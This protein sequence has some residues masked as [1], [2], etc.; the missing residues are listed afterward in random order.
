MKKK[1][2]LI[3]LA[4]LLVLTLAF[5][6]YAAVYYRAADTALKALES[7]EVLVTE[8]EYGWFFD[9]PSTDRVLVFY[10]GAK[11]EETAYAP[12]LHR[13]AEQGVDVCLV[14]MPFHLAFFRM[15]AADSLM[16]QYDYEKWYI[17]GHSLGGA[18]AADYAASHD[19]DGVILLAAY[20]TRDV[21]EP[22]LILYG[23]ED[24]VLNRG[25]IAAADQY[26]T[27]EEIVIEGGNHALFGDYGEQSGD[28]AAE[29]SAE[30][31]Q[32]ITADAILSWL[33]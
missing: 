16:A 10:P 24:G 11:V 27:V 33:P 26:G 9:G 2:W 28:H 14:K 8:T 30:E 6:L 1:P 13:L 4:L 7:D 3:S 32:R 25:R 29:I 20:P 18:I 23:S 15:N 19:L 22:M 12:L 31:Q 21:D 5:F 17:G